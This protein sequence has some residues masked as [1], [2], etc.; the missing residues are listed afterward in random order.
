MLGLELGY[1]EIKKIFLRYFF[2]LLS[3]VCWWVKILD[4]IIEFINNK[5]FEIFGK[6]IVCFV[7]IKGSLGKLD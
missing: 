5:I 7:F 4:K 3:Y 6:W 2:M 1:L